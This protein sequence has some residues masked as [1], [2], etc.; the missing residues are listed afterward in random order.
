MYTSVL[1]SPWGKKNG[2]MTWPSRQTT[3]NTMTVAGNLHAFHAS[4]HILGTDSQPLVV[5][6]VV[7][8]VLAEVLFV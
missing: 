6:R 1:L 5:L 4:W 3:P 2:G 7:G 8:L